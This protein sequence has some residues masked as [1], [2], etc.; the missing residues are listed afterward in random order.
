[1]NFMVF[2]PEMIDMQPWSGCFYLQIAYC[3]IQCSIMYCWSDF[4]L[5]L[6]I[7]FL[8]HGLIFNHRRSG[9]YLTLLRLILI[10]RTAI[11]WWLAGLGIIFENIWLDKGQRAFMFM[12]FVFFLHQLLPFLLNEF[13]SLMDLCGI[14]MWKVIF[15]L[16]KLSRGAH[17]YIYLSSRI[18]FSWNANTT[19]KDSIKL[20][21]IQYNSSFFKMEF[22]L[23]IRHY[24]SFKH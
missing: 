2:W 8:E 1:M 23:F 18:Y 9:E 17:Y 10:I 14:V 5:T 12:L 16:I 20:N 15:S 24:M 19:N 13:K 11:F 7:C 4:V 3:T 22:I 21:T 6:S